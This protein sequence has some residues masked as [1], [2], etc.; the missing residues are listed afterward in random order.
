MKK[1]EELV[2]DGILVKFDEKLSDYSYTKTGGIVD[3]MFFPH[4]IN[5][6]EKIVTWIRNNNKRFVV[7]GDMTNVAIASGNLDF[8][9]INMS[10]FNIETPKWDGNRILTVSAGWKMKELAVWCI[11]ND[12]RGLAW[13]EG[14]PGTVGAGVYMNAGFLLGQDMGTYLVDVTYLDLDDMTTHILRNQDLKFR[15]RFSKFHEMNV[16]ILE[17]RFLLNKI[18]NDWKKIYRRI[19]YKKIMSEYHTRRIDNQPISLPSAGTT[20]VPPYPW[21]VGGM[22]RELNL[23]GFKIGGAQISTKSPG[24]IVGIDHMTGEDYFAMVE[25]IQNKIKESFDIDLEPEVRLL[26]NGSKELKK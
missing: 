6:L 17:C 20:F 2:N 14:I 7:L 10:Q 8:V 12:I 16:I 4:N 15:Y 1:I 21:H 24:F 23:V 13:M 5:D 25:F 9:V 26:S 11:D 19:R 22:L 3:L 18:P